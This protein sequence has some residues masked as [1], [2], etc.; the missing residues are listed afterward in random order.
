VKTA[1]AARCLQK[2]WETIV[3]SIGLIDGWLSTI[4]RQDNIEQGPL[5]SC[6]FW[7]GNS[8]KHLLEEVFRDEDSQRRREVQFLRNLPGMA[9]H[10]PYLST[11]NHFH[12][13]SLKERVYSP[14]P[15][16]THQLKSAIRREVR[17]INSETCRYV[18]NNFSHRLDVINAQNGRHVERLL[19]KILQY[20]NCLW[21]LY[22]IKWYHRIY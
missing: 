20:S 18:I 8:T 19:V 17:A 7:S 14:M 9:A 4:P 6:T 12:G 5:K 15:E 1:S 22:Q 21:A 2:Q 16:S 10:S 11:L 3:V 13:G